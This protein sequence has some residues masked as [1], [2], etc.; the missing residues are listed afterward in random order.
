M[1]K[2]RCL[3]GIQH[4]RELLS[5]TVVLD[6]LRVG[7]LN[8]RREQGGRAQESNILTRSHPA[9]YGVFV[10][11]LDVGETAGKGETAA[12]LQTSDATRD[13]SRGGKLT[14]QK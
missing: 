10:L 8:W 13:Q 3:W 11:G 1:A 9:H 7:L 12:P 2:G 14:G 4:W 6:Q 5:Q